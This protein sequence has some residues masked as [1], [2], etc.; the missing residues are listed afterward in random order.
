[1]LA[2][3]ERDRKREGEKLPL[4]ESDWFQDPQSVSH[5]LKVLV[6]GPLDLACL[7]RL[8]ADITLQTNCGVP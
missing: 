7:K 5:I 6:A 1:M 3:G 8:P 2:G 4:V